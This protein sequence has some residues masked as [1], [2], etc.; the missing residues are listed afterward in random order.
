[1]TNSTTAYQV[2]DLIMGLLRAAAPEPLSIKVLMNGGSI[3][4]FNGNQ[5]RVAVTRLCQ[6]QQLSCQERGIYELS[7]LCQ[8]SA[9]LS[10]DW[11][12]GEGRLRDWDGS[13]HTVIIPPALERSRHRR[14]LQA[15]HH[16]GF[17]LG[18]RSL[19]L[20]PNNLWLDTEQVRQRLWGL[21]LD[22]SCQLWES[23]AFS[24][25][26]V[27]DL[28]ALWGHEGWDKAHQSARQQ[29]ECSLLNL[30]KLPSDEQLRESFILGGESIRLLVT[31]PLLPPE[32]ADC[33]E[34]RLHT[35]MM[36]QY[37]H[38]GRELWLD[39]LRSWKREL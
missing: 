36:K 24:V 25:D 11:H 39:K 27:K 31:D 12:L 28:E 8:E 37:N 32:I 15:L 3:F 5:I 29:L 16:L 17:R 13:W 18:F 7:V 4:G 20:R 21:G 34:R 14:A 9:L 35:E 38:A 2:K 23:R 26:L 1:M 30:L 22:A 33:K 6:A 10:R 19:Y